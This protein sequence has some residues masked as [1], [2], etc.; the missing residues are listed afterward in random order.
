M[1]PIKSITAVLCLMAGLFSLG[2]H[3]PKNHEAMN[4]KSV[5]EFVS[6][7]NAHDVQ[8][9]VSLMSGT[10]V[11]EDE[12]GRKTEGAAAISAG[13]EGYFIMFPGYKLDLGQM[14]AEGDEVMGFGHAEN[15]AAE[16]AWRIPVAVR[17]VVQDG[18]V[19]HWQV[20]ADTQIPA[21]SKGATSL[22]ELGARATSIGGLFFKCKDPAALREW[23]KTHLGLVT[24]E[25]GSVFEWHQGVDSTQKGYT[26][27]SPFSEKTKYFEPSTKDF[28]I[29][30]RVEG[31][32]EL[33]AKMKA[34]GVTICDE[35]AAYDYGKFVHIM[36]PEGNKIELWEPID[37]VFATMGSGTTK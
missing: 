17:A 20:V 31:M 18:K 8:R 26:Q 3:P 34:A 32:E 5:Q 13:W 37:K 35:V 19:A 21:L 29:N 36:D 9:V 7:I 12:Q 4:K 1:T 11:F 14:M 27:W 28:M 22:S 10:P 23:Y 33:L 24:N 6:A 16:G 30:Y 25:Y 15:A 2:F